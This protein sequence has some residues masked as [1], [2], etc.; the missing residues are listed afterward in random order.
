VRQ[1]LQAGVHE[2]RVAQVR[3]PRHARLGPKPLRAPQRGRRCVM[4]ALEDCQQPWP[5]A[6]SMLGT[7]FWRPSSTGHQFSGWVGHT[8]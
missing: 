7:G 4:S 1:A 6:P 3:E 8:R 5:G 2:A